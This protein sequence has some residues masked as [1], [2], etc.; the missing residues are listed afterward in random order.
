[1]WGSLCTCRVRRADTAAAIMITTRARQLVST[2]I[3]L[4]SQPEVMRRLTALL[5]DPEVGV[6]DVGAL[7][8]EDPV[9]AAKVL[10]IANSAFYGLRERCL[11]PQQ[12]ASVLGLKVLRNVIL[13]AC[14]MRQF[15]H[16]QAEDFDLRAHW[17]HSVLCAQLCASLA[18]QTTAQIE[19]RPEE[20]Y[21]CG[22]LH[23]LGQL[24]LAEALGKNYLVV[25]E[26]AR[27]DNLP[28]HAVESAH[29]GFTHAD[30]GGLIAEQWGLPPA[31]TLAIGQH[32]ELGT[33]GVSA[34]VKAA[35]WLAHALEAGV[36]PDWN[37]LPQDLRACFASLNQEPQLLLPGWEALASKVSGISLS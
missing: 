13:Q 20:L 2:N 7:I 8:A 6:G 37:S 27:R 1:M 34:I 26:Q 3:R 12:A 17:R 14:A 15:E 35:D 23:D 16:L 28:R 22:L 18:V 11:A 36:Q 32:H 5:D 33:E 19:L 4:P 21:A 29:L 9:L 25:L 24:V 30:V 10:K 31:A